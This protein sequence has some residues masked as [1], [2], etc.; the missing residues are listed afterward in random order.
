MFLSV[1]R[2]NLGDTFCKPFYQEWLIGE[3]LA[4]RVKAPGMITAWRDR[5]GAGRYRYAAWV[6]SCWNGQVKPSTDMHKL[7]KGLQLA[8]NNGFLSFD[9]ASRIATGTKWRDNIKKQKREREVAFEA[10]VPLSS[11]AGQFTDAEIEETKEVKTV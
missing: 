6:K 1:Q 4:E 9:K 10:K 2:T 7:M 11:D 8:V 3:V 5:T